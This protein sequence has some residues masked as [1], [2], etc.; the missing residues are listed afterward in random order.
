MDKRF[1]EVKTEHGTYTAG[2]WNNEKPFYGNLERIQ[3]LKTLAMNQYG[4]HIDA[5]FS[6]GG[7]TWSSNF[8]ALAADP[9]K[10]ERFAQTAVALVQQYNMDGLDLDW[11][12]AV[13]GNQNR[14]S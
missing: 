5:I 10:R 12:F 2:D 7:W 8:E 13:W 4:N 3:Q 14:C 1:P 6:V 11:E 9:V